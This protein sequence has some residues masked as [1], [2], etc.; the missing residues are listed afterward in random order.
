MEIT[1]IDDLDQFEELKT[2]W[3]AVYS[4]DDRAQIFLSWAWLR[5]WFEVTP[6]PWFVLAVRLDNRS[7]YVGFFPLSIR[8]VQKYKLNLFRELRMGGD[9]SA[10]YTGF[11]C[12]PEYEEKAISAFAIYV[13]QQLEWDVFLMKNVLD[14]RLDIFLKYFSQNNFKVQEVNRT[15]CPYIPLPKTWDQYLQDFLGSNTRQNLRRRLRKIETS[16]DF[17]FIQAQE[18][19]IENQIEALLTLWQQRWGLKPEQLLN[20]KRSIFRRCFENN[21]LWLN[22]LWKGKTP[23]AAIGIFVEQQKKIFYFYTTGYDAKFSNLAPGRMMMAYS[24]RYAIEN[25]FQVY[26][27]LR[28]DEDYKF[29]FFGAKKRFNTSVTI[30]RT[31]LRGTL[32]NLIRR[33][34]KSLKEFKSSEDQNSGNPV[35]P[36]E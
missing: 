28:G 9:S 10:D 34:R 18:D 26:D 23:I 16:T 11:I 14:P 33:S 7:P 6:N 36:P 32:I 3:D 8:F 22:V 15:C 35:N 1:I 27:L 5:G 2:A 20:V 12:L 24:I 4:S 13:Q 30:S 19:N 21:C 17:R 29:S 25:G 31:S